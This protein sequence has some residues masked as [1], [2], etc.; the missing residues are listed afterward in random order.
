DIAAAEKIIQREAR[1]SFEALQV[2]ASALPGLKQLELEAGRLDKNLDS[3]ATSSLNNLTTAL[4]D[5]TMGTKSAGDAFRNLGLQV[6]RSLEEMLIKMLI[7]QPIAA[8]LQATLKGLMGGVG[9]GA[10]VDLNPGTIG[11]TAGS[12]S[13]I[14]HAGGIVGQ[15]VTAM[16]YVHPAYF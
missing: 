10:P 4:A 5:I 13:P 12:L 7:V 3:A 8:A 15:S 1:N 6:I 9:F 14:H 16:R 2:R 11:G